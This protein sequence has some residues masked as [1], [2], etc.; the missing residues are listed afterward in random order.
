MLANWPLKLSFPHGSNLVSKLELLGLWPQCQKRGPYDPSATISRG[1][2]PS[3][4][5][6]AQAREGPTPGPCQGDP[7]PHVT[8]DFWI[9]PHRFSGEAEFSLLLQVYIK[10][11]QKVGRSHFLSD[12]WSQ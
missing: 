8:S 1:Y 9:C 4:G 12:T 5:P 11:T 10:E 3:L 6:E 7:L 2:P